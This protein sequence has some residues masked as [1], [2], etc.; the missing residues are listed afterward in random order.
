MDVKTNYGLI[1]GDLGIEAGN[2]VFSNQVHGD[3]CEVIFEKPPGGRVQIPCDA[4]ITDRPE[5]A[6]V[7]HFADCVPV[8]LFDPKKGVCSIIHSGWKGTAKD[9]VARVVDKIKYLFNCNPGDIHVALGPAIGKCCFETHDD[10]VMEFRR[11]LKWSEKYMTGLTSGKYRIDLK[12]VIVHSLI[13]N[14]VKET[15]IYKSPL[16]TKCHKDIF[17]SHRGDGGRTGTMAGI[18]QM[19]GEFSK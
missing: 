1:L 11:R 7:G 19:T 12:S 18:I 4:L 2:L 8:F 6:L 15:N 3:N 14:G 17:F 16:C 10:V 13:M 9:I 5:I